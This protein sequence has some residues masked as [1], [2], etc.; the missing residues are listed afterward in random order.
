MIFIR[1]AIFLVVGSAAFRF[2]GFYVIQGSNVLLTMIYVPMLPD[3][4]IVGFTTIGAI[5]GGIFGAVL[6][7]ILMIP[8]HS[9][10]FSF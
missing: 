8:T 5:V 2:L 4:V 6:P 9:R 10:D 3:H 7:G 1:V